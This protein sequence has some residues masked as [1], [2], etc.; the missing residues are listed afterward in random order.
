MAF[1]AWKTFGGLGGLAGSGALS[2]LA[3]GKHDDGTFS[4]RLS[5]DRSHSFLGDV[6]LLGAI[7]TGLAAQYVSGSQ[8]KKVLETV[9]NASAMSLVSTEA[10]RWR[11]KGVGGISDAPFAPDFKFGAV[12]IGSRPRT[13]AWAGR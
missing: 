10:V 11:L 4:L 1:D 5:L 7:A 2:Y 13:A 8:T 6:R 9:A 3:A 12:G